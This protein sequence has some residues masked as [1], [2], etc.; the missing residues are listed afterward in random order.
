MA[1]LLRPL[2]LVVCVFLASAEVFG[3]GG[4]NNDRC[5]TPLHDAAEG[6]DQ[7][8]VSELLASRVDVDA[9][10]PDGWTPLHEAAMEG[11]V[12]VVNLLLAAG[13]DPLARS[14]N[15]ER[16][17]PRDV[18]YLRGIDF[19]KMRIKGNPYRKVEDFFEHMLNRYELI[20]VLLKEAER[21]RKDVPL[22]EK[23]EEENMY[24]GVFELFEGINATESLE[25]YDSENGTVS[26]QIRE[27]FRVCL[28]EMH[29]VV[30]ASS[31]EVVEGVENGMLTMELNAPED[32]FGE[33]DDDG[34]VRVQLCTTHSN[35]D[36]RS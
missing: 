8:L 25:A 15:N 26:A 2:L 20:I 1:Y 17:S 5:R 21:A 22:R 18:A 14:S 34:E 13:A 12:E 35:L 36:S 29:E 23:L 4:G 9:V 31:E 28:C 30:A 6:G 24:V 27:L 32:N 10:D 11:H 7:D 3:G 16:V 19:I 33:Y